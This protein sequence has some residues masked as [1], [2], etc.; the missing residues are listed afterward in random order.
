MDVSFQGGVGAGLA[1]G[2]LMISGITWAQEVPSYE[3]DFSQPAGKI[4]AING[5]NLG[6]LYKGRNLTTATQDFKALNFSTVR[7]HDVP[8]DNAGMRLVDYQM[9]FGNMDA[10]PKDPKNYYFEQTD[11]YIRTILDCGPK[12]VYRLG[13][14]IEWS[15]KKYFVKEPKDHAH[16]AEL[17]A[18]IVRHYNKGWAN[19][20]QWNIEYWEIWNEP[21]LPGNMWDTGFDNYIKFYVDVA[22]RLKTEFP[23]IKVGG[24]VLTSADRVQASKFVKA[25]RKEG[26]ALDFFSWH[27]YIRKS[28]QCAESANFVRKLLD[29]HGF[30]KAELHFNEWHYFPCEWSAL[31]TTEGLRRWVDTA[32]GM[33]G[34]DSAAFNTVCLSRW[35]DLP[36]DMANFYAT[37][38]AQW[39][40]RRWDGSFRPTYYSLQAFGRFAKETPVRVRTKD[41][42]NDSVTILGGVGPNGEKQMLVTA[43][44][45]V[46]PSQSIKL[47]G[48][49]SK[50]TANVLRLDASTTGFKEEAVPYS[51]GVIRLVT[52]GSTVLLVRF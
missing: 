40:L 37:G 18:G 11:D 15:A 4:R 42:G 24:P 10:D 9:I 49:P 34:I 28:S 1:V 23:E 39:G 27:G 31:T 21:N 44:Q 48:V 2:A 25:C 6:P 52:Q 45:K 30:A 16:F 12:I 38:L 26:A 51:D 8:L 22:K 43:F 35:Q 14:S 41:S 29:D 47:S 46:Q 50:G 5:T 33:N 36:L 7:L 19:G 3:V 32:D 17:C 20:H 13:P